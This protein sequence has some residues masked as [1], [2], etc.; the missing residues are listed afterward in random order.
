MLFLSEF[1]RRE[2]KDLKL[3]V[4]ATDVD[5][6]ALRIAATGVYPV[7]ALLEMPQ[8]LVSQRKYA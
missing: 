1:E 3:K 6:D 7:S 5:T 8:P 4:F 2:R